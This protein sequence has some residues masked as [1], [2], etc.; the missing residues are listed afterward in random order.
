MGYDVDALSL[1]RAYPV[2]GLGS[3]GASCLYAPAM[4]GPVPSNLV[5]LSDLG[6]CTPGMK[7]R[8]LGW[9]SI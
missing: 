6:T 7:V 8:F 4:S 3:A 9:Y 2:S 5:L 1:A